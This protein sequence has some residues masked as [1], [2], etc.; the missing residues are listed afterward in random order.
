MVKSIRSLPAKGVSPWSRRRLKSVQAGRQDSTVGTREMT[1]IKNRLVDMGKLNTAVQI[2]Y[3]TLFLV[4]NTKDAGLEL[5]LCRA[6]NR[7]LAAAWAA[8]P[9]QIKWVV[10]LPLASIKESID[11]IRFAKQNGAVEFSFAASRMSTPWTIPICFQS[12]KK[13]KNK[14]YPSAFTPA[15]A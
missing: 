13:R 10:V 7:F 12:T 1:D 14:I 8:A 15:A 9:D 5:A 6:Y 3:P 2:V 11:E 4:Y